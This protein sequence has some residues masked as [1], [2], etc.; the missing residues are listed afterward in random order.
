[1]KLRNFIF[2][3]NSVEDPEVYEEEVEYFGGQTIFDM[4]GPTLEI[5]PPQQSPPN[6]EV[7]SMFFEVNRLIMA[8]D[9]DIEQTLSD[10]DEQMRG[11]LA[12]GQETRMTLEEV[13]AQ[14][15]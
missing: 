9:A 7:R 5:S 15:E 13:K 10:F 2:A 8:E 12:D 3:S 6:P 4:L 11:T 14:A 1:M